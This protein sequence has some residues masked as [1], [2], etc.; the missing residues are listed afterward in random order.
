MNLFMYDR[1]AQVPFVLRAKR[2]SL[3]VAQTYLQRHHIGGMAKLTDGAKSGNVPLFIFQCQL[4]CKME[5]GGKYALPVLTR[6][7]ILPS[8]E[9]QR[10]KVNAMALS[11]LLDAMLDQLESAGDQ[12][13]AP[14]DTSFDPNSFGGAPSTQ[15]FSAEDGGE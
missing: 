1:E 5:P 4:S 6:G 2:T 7:R 8:A 12:S 14:P 3:P 15:G 10:H 11:E 9:V 13:E